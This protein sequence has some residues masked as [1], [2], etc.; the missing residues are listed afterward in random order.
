MVT[1]FTIIKGGIAK[2]IPHLSPQVQFSLSTLKWLKLFPQLSILVQ[3][4]PYADVTL[5]VG[6]S[7]QQSQVVTI[8]LASL[9]ATQCIKTNFT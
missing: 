2:L 9:A 5:H 3:F 6:S 1:T 4:R 7:S 8:A